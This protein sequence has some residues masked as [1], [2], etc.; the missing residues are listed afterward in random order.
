MPQMTPAIVKPY[1]LFFKLIDGSTQAFT[2]TEGNATTV[3]SLIRQ[4]IERQLPV[5]WDPKAFY[6]VHNGRPLY[7][8]SGRTL[9]ECNVVNQATIFV[10]SRCY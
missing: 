2:P 3:E 7:S 1:Q 9:R 10:V 4:L 8:A 5:E 6:L